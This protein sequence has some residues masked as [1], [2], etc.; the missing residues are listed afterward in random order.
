MRRRQPL[1]SDADQLARLTRMPAGVWVGVFWVVSLAALVVGA[2]LLLP[3]SL[4]HL[5]H[6]SH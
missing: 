6:L 1:T 5:G 2:R 3:V 4:A